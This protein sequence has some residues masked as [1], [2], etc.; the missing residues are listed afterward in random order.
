MQPINN[1]KPEIKALEIGD[2]HDFHEQIDFPTSIKGIT[3][4]C[5]F[6]IKTGDENILIDETIEEQVEV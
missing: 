1:D 4:N 3:L 5:I 2:Y 6:E